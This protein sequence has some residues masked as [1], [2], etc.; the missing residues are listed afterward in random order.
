MKLLFDQNL[1]PRLVA[2]L[3]DHYPDSAHVITHALDHALDETVWA[4]AREH[5]Y[6]L[7]TKDSDFHELGLRKRS[8]I[9]LQMGHAK[10]FILALYIQNSIIYL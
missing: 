6:T 8:F 7:V 3:A 2:K 1:S 10:H 4:F 5:G 9:K